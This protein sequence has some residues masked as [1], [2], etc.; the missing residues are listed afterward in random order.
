MASAERSKEREN[1]FFFLKA[2]EGKKIEEGGC[3]V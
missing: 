1:D 3:F 2:W